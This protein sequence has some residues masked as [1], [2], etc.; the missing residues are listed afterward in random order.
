MVSVLKAFS[1]SY[2]ML[3]T[4]NAVATPKITIKH[5]RSAD[6]FAQVQIINETTK[7][8]LCYV[9]IDGHK[10]KFKLNERQK[11]KWYKATDSRFN[12]QNFSTWCDYF[13]MHL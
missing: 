9:A 13:N 4:L 1:F 8:L 3:F 11:S 6:N 2:L 12:H 5:K 7:K 10:I